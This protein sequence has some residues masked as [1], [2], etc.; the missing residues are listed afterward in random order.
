MASMEAEIGT[1]A[2]RIWRYLEQHGETVV[3]SVRRGT[4][5]SDPLLFMGLGWLGPEGK[6]TLVRDKRSVR[7]SLKGAETASRS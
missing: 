4:Q 5:L 2:G 6:V 3:G 7:A 1:A